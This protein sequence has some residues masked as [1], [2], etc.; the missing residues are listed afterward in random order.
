MERISGQRK[1]NWMENSWESSYKNVQELEEERLK[2]V[3]LQ[4]QENVL[5]F[6]LPVIFLY[7]MLSWT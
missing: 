4:S 1:T 5:A 2:P 7:R 6:E 3:F